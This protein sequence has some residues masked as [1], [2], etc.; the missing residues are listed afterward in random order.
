MDFDPQGQYPD[1]VIK[2][3]RIDAPPSKVWRA[4]TVP[5]EAVA[6]MSDEPL[7]LITDWIVGAPI[8]IR[9]ILHG[10]LRFENSG[11]VEAFEP[12]R[13]LQYSHWSSLSRR[14]LPDLAHNHV[15]IRFELQA[16]GAGTDLRLTLSNLGSY[17]V[18]G[19]I[20]YYWEIALAALKRH[21]ESAPAS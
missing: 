14:V 12:E 8:L 13:V 16:S 6:W 19:H 2:H 11:R 4:L 7:E 10:R 3:I 21:C 15:V 9:G 1:Q 20:N 17:A 18:Y 5:S